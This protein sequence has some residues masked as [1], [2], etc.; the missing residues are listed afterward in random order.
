MLF[1]YC[2]FELKL[3]DSVGTVC[4]GKKKKKKKGAASDRSGYMS[5][6]GPA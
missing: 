6:P 2:I 5:A 3:S 1:F 4:A